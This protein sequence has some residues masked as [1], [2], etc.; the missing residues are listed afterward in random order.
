MDVCFDSIS[1]RDGSQTPVLRVVPCLPVNL[2]SWR[3]T[4]Y[5]I[6]FFCFRSISSQILALETRCL[7]SSSNQQLAETQPKLADATV[8]RDPQFE[9]LPF[10]RGV[11]YSIMT[12]GN[13]ATIVANEIQDKSTSSLPSFTTIHFLNKHNALNSEL[14]FFS[15]RVYSLIDF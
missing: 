11:F 12:G 1:S 2:Q 5:N 9:I 7:D 13:S 15:N 14:Y 8:V 4:V 10:E 3:A 6:F